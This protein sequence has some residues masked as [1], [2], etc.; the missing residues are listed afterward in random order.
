MDVYAFRCVLGYVMCVYAFVPLCVC[1]SPHI[2]LCVVCACAFV[3]VYVCICVYICVGTYVPVSLYVRVCLCIYKGIS[4]LFHVCFGV[5]V[6][7]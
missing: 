3:C 4:M 1:A 6:C 5:C 7:T 2:Y